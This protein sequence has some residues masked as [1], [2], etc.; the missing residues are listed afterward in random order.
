[1]MN[2]LV[3][4]MCQYQVG[5]TDNKITTTPIK[6]NAKDGI[7]IS[8]PTLYW[9]LVGSLIYL[10]ILRHDINY[11]VHIVNQYMIM[12]RKTHFAAVLQFFC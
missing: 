2:S 7:P 8:N 9:R 10:T 1:M 4:F 3:K 5:L 11:V 12:P 6:T